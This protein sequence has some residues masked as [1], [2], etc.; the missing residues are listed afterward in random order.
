MKM[1]DE[2]DTACKM[3]VKVHIGGESESATKMNLRA[4][5]FKMII[6]EPENMGG[7]NE[8]HSPVQVLLMALA[9]CLNVTGHQVAKEKRFG[10]FKDEYYN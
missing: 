3:Q 2:I 6:D 5:K 1:I 10:T 4:G 8:G 9:G 7:S